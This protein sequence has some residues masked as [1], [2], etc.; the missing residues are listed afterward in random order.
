MDTGTVHFNTYGWHTIWVCL[1]SD[2]YYRCITLIYCLSTVCLCIIYCLFT[3]SVAT[4]T[5]QKGDSL[6][7]T[8][9]AISSSVSKVFSFCHIVS[10]SLLVPRAVVNLTKKLHVQVF[11][12][13]YFVYLYV[14][15]VRMHCSNTVHSIPLKLYFCIVC[16]V[17]RCTYV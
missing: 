13:V 17:H 11:P 4:Q 8:V 3:L 15:P 9:A 1:Y 14:R 6:P 7:D 10:V 2:P 16:V 5:L 12:T